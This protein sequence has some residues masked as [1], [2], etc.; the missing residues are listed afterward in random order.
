[1][2]VCVCVFVCVCARARPHLASTFAT[3]ASLARVCVLVREP[4]PEREPCGGAARA[5]RD[6][7]VGNAHAGVVRLL[8]ELL[9]SVCVWGG[10]GEARGIVSARTRT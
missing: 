2:C 10:G 7:H 4:R 3:A 6:H 9:S 5:R 8:G 1:M